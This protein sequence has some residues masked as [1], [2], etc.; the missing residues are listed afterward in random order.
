MNFFY[1]IYDALWLYDVSEKLSIFSKCIN[2]W[3]HAAVVYEIIN[4]QAR[5]YTRAGWER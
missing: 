1:K 2:I 3:I 5:L 4:V